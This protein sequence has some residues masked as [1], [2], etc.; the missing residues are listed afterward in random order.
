MNEIYLERLG[1]IVCNTYGIK[2]QDHYRVG[3]LINSTYKLLEEEMMRDLRE[4]A[5]K[6]QGNANDS[7]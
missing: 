1:R 4:A 5:N 6:S 7:Q 3:K 2:E